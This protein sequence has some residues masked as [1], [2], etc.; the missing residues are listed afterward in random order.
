MGADETQV[1]TSSLSAVTVDAAA[2]KPPTEPAV[3]TEQRLCAITGLPAKYRDP[4]S[5]LPYANLDAFR[6]L[7]K[8]HP[9]PK[10]PTASAETAS[11]QP[12]EPPRQPPQPPIILSTGVT[13]RINKVA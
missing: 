12:A 2:P 13:R 11:H 1:L 10:A 8:L 3:G 7:R 5:G 4:V 9:D 6:E